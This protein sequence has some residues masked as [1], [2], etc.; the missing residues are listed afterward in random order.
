MNNPFL[1]KLLPYILIF[2]VSVLCF[3]FFLNKGITL[4]DE[5]FIAESSY[6]TYLGK[7]P[8]RDFAFPYTPLSLWLGSLVFHI[9]GVGLLKLRFLALVVSALSVTLGYWIARKVAGLNMAILAVAAT[10]IWGFPQTN[11]LWP[12]SLVLLPFLLTLVFVI[13]ALEKKSPTYFFF[14]GVSVALATLAKQN[15][16]AAL[17][18][19]SLILLLYLHLTK[20]KS[21]KVGP[22]ILGVMST[23]FVSLTLLIIGDPGLIGIRE[24]FYRSI[25]AL[26]GKILLSGYDSVPLSINLKENIKSIA[27]LLFYFSPVFLLLVVLYSKIKGIKIRPKV[28]GVFLLTFIFVVTIA[29][30]TTDLVHFTF[31]VPAIA[32]GFAATYS[33]GN[34]HIKSVSIFF[35]LMLI[36]VGI[37]KTFFMGYYAFEAPYPKFQNPAY[38]RSGRVLVDQKHKTIISALN[39]YNQTILKDKSVFVYSYAP[40]IYFILDKDPPVYDLYTQENL[41]SPTSIDQDVNQLKESR[42]DFVLVEKWRW[43]DSKI[44][45]YI[46]SNYKIVLTIWDFDLWKRVN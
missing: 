44:S 31:A 39:E 41:I 23:A 4:Y 35:I 24:T 21:L 3:S 9:F 13:K 6:L 22:F 40:M 25:N 34:K 5:G 7:I 17:F 19:G 38:I 36:V 16:G 37:Y 20:E 28:F 42:P 43:V 1:K 10:L 30:P 18:I 27:K 45:R 11:F 26:S 29:W 15:I 2:F 32:L 8:Y 33:L 12:S 14:T 46:K